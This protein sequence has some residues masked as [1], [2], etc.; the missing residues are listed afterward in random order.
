M[1][2][3]SNS[4][5]DKYQRTLVKARMILPDKPT[6]VEPGIMKAVAALEPPSDLCMADLTYVKFLLVSEHENGNADYFARSEMA[7][8]WQTPRHKPFN[9]EH[10]LEENASY[11][12]E[13][14]L[15]HNENTII[16]HMVETAVVCDGKILNEQAIADLDHNDDPLRP[17]DQKI[18]IVASAVLYKMC[19]PKTVADIEESAEKGEMFVSMETWFTGFDFLVGDEI[20]KKTEATAYLMDDWHHSK[21]V[22]GRRVSRVL[23]GLLFGGVAATA[24][25][26]NKTS[27]FLTASMEKELSTL[28]KRH[29]ELHVLFEAEPNDDIQDEHREVTLSIACM[30]YEME[31]A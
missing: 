16:G 21:V 9:V 31:E 26:A 6:G 5:F 4:P 1:A 25:P 30:K 23:R 22:A 7:R 8:A 2:E 14:I 27:V 28:E 12:E 13:P 17:V 11:I 24:K 18:D 15:N 19:F 10:Q 3:K 20:V 29:H